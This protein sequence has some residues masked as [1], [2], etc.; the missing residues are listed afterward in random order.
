MIRFLNGFEE[1]LQQW[2]SWDI[3]TVIQN[4][5]LIKDHLYD[6]FHQRLKVQAYLFS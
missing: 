2:R 3:I 1:T 5:Q 6:L 4:H